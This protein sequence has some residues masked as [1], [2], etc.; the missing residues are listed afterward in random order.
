MVQKSTR[1][2]GRLPLGTKFPAILRHAGEALSR[3]LCANRAAHIPEFFPC[4]Q[5]RKDDGGTV[6]YLDDKACRIPGHWPK[7]V[8]RP[9]G[10]RFTFLP[11]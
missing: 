11:R 9:T 1:E 5:L 8:K 2:L 4:W 7:D 10:R 6:D 3:H